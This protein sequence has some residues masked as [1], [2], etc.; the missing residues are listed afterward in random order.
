MLGSYGVAA[1]KWLWIVYSI[2]FVL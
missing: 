1:W 2:T